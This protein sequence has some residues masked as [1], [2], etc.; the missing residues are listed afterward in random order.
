MA[1]FAN[2]RDKCRMAAGG[3]SDLDLSQLNLD[4]SHAIAKKGGE[5][6][7]YQQAP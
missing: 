5:G 4:G 6:V 2:R 3:F 1:S 7:A